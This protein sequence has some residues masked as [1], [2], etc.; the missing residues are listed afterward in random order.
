MESNAPE[1]PKSNGVEA[2][3]R[4]DALARERDTLLEQVSGLRRS[5]E[6]LQEK[7]AVEIGDIRVQLEKTQSGKEAAES[8]YEDLRDRVTTIRNTLGE[9]LKEYSVS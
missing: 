9:R 7:H 3:E 1:A 8:K 2:S 4:L 6:A 5:L